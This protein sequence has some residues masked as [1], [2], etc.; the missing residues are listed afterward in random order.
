MENNDISLKV[1]AIEIYPGTSGESN[2]ELEI[3]AVIMRDDELFV[4]VKQPAKE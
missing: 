4:Y 2:H 3:E 1:R